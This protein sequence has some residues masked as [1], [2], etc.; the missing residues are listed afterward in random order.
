[1]KKFLKENWFVAVIAVLFLIGTIWFIYDQ[2]KDDLPG[3]KANGK[4]VVY[5]L[6]DD[7]VTADEH[8]ENLYKV[9]G[10]DIIVK[11]FMDAVA[12]ASV[13]T[14]EDLEAEAEYYVSYYSSLYSAYGGISYL[15]QIAQENYGYSDFKTYILYSIKDRE[16]CEEYVSTHIEEYLTDEFFEK[17]E[18][19]II[20]Y[21]LIKFDDPENP[22]EE[23]TI[24]FN[25]AK[26][27]WESD[28]YTTANFAD[29]AKA[30]SEDSSTANDGG[31]LGYVD[32]QSSL[33]EAFK[34]EAL[35]L[36]EGEVSDWIYSQEYGWF[37]IRCD[38][39]SYDDIA[40]ES[41]LVSRILTENE[42]LSNE[43]IWYNA[44]QH[45]VKFANETVKEFIMKELGITES[46][47]N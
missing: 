38:S 21:V 16:M 28:Q 34:N 22:T 17:Y 9:Y 1:M 24:R 10:E 5:S 20:S 15:N 36:E 27:A 30:Y 12:D 4:D 29:F 37:L 41:S 44:T 13:K 7:Y 46:E 25:T 14:T 6:D 43:I 35:Q 32:N 23:E 8:Y 26:D 19:R 11:Q 33:V 31:R 47:G 40:A 3:K 39:Q 42:D 45:N 2:H 18:P